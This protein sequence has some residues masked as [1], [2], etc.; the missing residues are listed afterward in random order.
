ML[1][2]KLFMQRNFAAQLLES[3]GE[4]EYNDL[5]FEIGLLLG[6]LE[7]IPTEEEHAAVGKA[8][9]ML[10]EIQPTANAGEVAKVN[11]LLCES[12]TNNLPIY[13]YKIFLREWLLSID[14]NGSD[15]NNDECMEINAL[16]Q[17]CFNV[18]EAFIRDIAFQSYIKSGKYDNLAAMVQL[19]QETK[20]S[21]LSAM[22]TSK[23]AE[24]TPK[25]ALASTA[26]AAK[27]PPS[28]SWLTSIFGGGNRAQ[29]T[30]NNNNV[31][32]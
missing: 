6:P 11:D 27:Q 5:M 32:R 25:D 10:D 23:L 21:G 9:S 7:Y 30:G 14:S 3:K 24:M 4:D 15:L 16:T 13:Y 17:R 26:E 12:L 28:P 8:M 19:L 1:S 29:E 20:D 18:W 2:R 31:P 22:L